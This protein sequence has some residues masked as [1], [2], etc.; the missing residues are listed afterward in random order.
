MP[1]RTPAE[2]PKE[3]IKMSESMRIWKMAL[4]AGVTM[5][6]VITASCTYTRIDANRTSTELAK[7]A[8]MRGLSD[9]G[10]GQ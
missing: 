3:E 9:A 8:A 4:I 6:T 2:M 7:L 5:V 10:P 1:Y